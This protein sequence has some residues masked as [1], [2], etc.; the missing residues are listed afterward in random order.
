MEEAAKWL[1]KE[2]GG[3][4]ATPFTIPDGVEVSVRSGGGKRVFLLINFAQEPRHVTFGGQMKLLLSGRLGEA[5]ELAPYGVE[6]VVA[7]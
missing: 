1:V 6:V 5:V 2:S 3:N 4:P 7:P